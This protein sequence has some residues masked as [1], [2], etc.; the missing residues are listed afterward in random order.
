[1]KRQTLFFG[2]FATTILIERSFAKLRRRLNPVFNGVCA[3]A[4]AL[5]PRSA[6]RPGVSTNGTLRDRSGIGRPERSVA[7]I[8][9][10]GILAGSAR[11]DLLFLVSLF[12]CLTKPTPER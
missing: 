11:I 5:P 3:S 6:S 12:A 7:I 1:M 10:P 4:T 2:I 8:S 9:R